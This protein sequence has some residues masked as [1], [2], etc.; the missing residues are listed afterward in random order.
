MRPIRIVLDREDFATL[1]KGEPIRS[2]EP[3]SQVEIILLEMT[4][5][6][7]IAAVEGGP[8]TP[9]ILN[10]IHNGPSLA[11]EIVV[12]EMH[13]AEGGTWGTKVAQWRVILIKVI[14]ALRD[15]NNKTTRG[16]D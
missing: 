11:L 15:H 6:E 13:E 2:G 9:A 7:M 3:Q 5:K 14:G 4:P 12:H 16:G 8:Q 10:T 1:V